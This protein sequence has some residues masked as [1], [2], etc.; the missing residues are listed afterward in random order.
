MKWIVIAL[1]ASAAHAGECDGFD[2][3]LERDGVRV[4]NRKIEG[5][6]VRE[7][8]ATA[9]IETPP[10][11]VYALLRDIESYPSRIPPTVVAQKLARSCDA[12]HAPNDREEL[13][14][15]GG[16]KADSTLE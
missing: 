10:A 3:A 8:C 9:R 13:Y 1:V 12:A 5:S 11:E 15:V 4:F 6:A 14:R 7:L 16:G 2:F